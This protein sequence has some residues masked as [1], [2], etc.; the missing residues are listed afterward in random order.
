MSKLEIPFIPSTHPNDVF[1]FSIEGCNGAGKTTLLNRYKKDH[2]ETE[3]RLCVPDV[4]QTAKDMKRFMLFE[5]SQLCTALYYLAGAVEVFNSHNKNLAKVLFDR[6]IWSTFAAAYAKDET[7]IP[8][9]LNCLN[10]IKQQVFLPNL[11]IVLD[12]SFETAKA[13][14]SKKCNGGEFDKDEIEAFTKKRH[15]YDLLKEAGYPILFLDVNKKDAEEVYS[16]FLEMLKKINCHANK[17][18]K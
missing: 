18:V 4:F 5:S 7:I 10:A 2:P 1:V 11:I 15:F 17:I 6:S 3:C 8:I 12:A 9:L 13:R 14:S 16:E